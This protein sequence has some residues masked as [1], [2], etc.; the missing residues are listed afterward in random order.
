MT[1]EELK[2]KLKEIQKLKCESQ[3]LE[4][5]SAE[6][7]CPKRLYDTL[8][9]FSNQDDGG[10]IIFGID[11]ENDYREAGVYDAQDLQ[12]KINAQCLQMEPV[13]RPVLTV[14]Q[15]DG[16]SFVAAEIPGI[17]LAQRP[18]YYR[19]HGRLKG[20]YVRVG[21]SDEPMTEYEI[22]SYESF[23]RKYIIITFYVFS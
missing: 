2:E 8:S 10:T 6:K 16:K 20:A 13:V 3:I 18:C 4:L 7:G 19:G 12:K 17:D 15:K 5:K 14:A 1:V 9:S 11:E 22:Y 23:R 21:D